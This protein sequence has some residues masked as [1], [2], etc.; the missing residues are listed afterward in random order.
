MRVWESNP[1][2]RIERGAVSPGTF[3]DLRSRSRA[4]ASLAMFGDRNHALHEWGET[5]EG[6]AAAISP[7]VFEMLGVRPIVGRGFA[8]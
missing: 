5:W 1:A 8:R 3:L 6:R 4:L 7:S 2:Q